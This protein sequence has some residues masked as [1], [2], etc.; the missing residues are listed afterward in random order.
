MSDDLIFAPPYVQIA[1]ELDDAERIVTISDEP[2][3]EINT[4]MTVETIWLSDVDW[5]SFNKALNEEPDPEQIAA[6]HELFATP[7]PW[8]TTAMS[9]DKKPEENSTRISLKEKYEKW[10]YQYAWCNQANATVAKFDPPRYGWYPVRRCVSLEHQMYKIDAA[11]WTS[12]GWYKSNPSIKSEPEFV[13]A[14]N[15]LHDVFC[16]I[17]EC[18]NTAKEARELGEKYDPDYDPNLTKY[19]Y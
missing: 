4:E 3:I 10:I 11:Y 18:Q 17:D 7:S 19:L 16:F 2:Q 9:E 8:E 15:V 5:E 13:D 6:L 14:K 1:E 12:S